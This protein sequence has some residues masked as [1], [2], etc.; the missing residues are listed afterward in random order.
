MHLTF[1]VILRNRP[2]N[3]VVYTT[4]GTLIAATFLG[5][6]NWCKN[7]YHTSYY[8]TDGGYQYYY[9]HE[10]AKFFQ[11]SSQTVFEV[12]V[13]KQLT[14]QLAFSAC[15]FESQADVYNSLHGKD[16]QERLSK[17]VHFFRRS[18]IHERADGLDW[19][20]NVTR[21]EEG[22]FLYRLIHEFTDLG[23]LNEQCF[24]VYNNGN[25]RDIESF[26]QKA[27]LVISTSPPRWVQ[28]SCTIPGCIL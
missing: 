11:T 8:E 26:C 19:M 18:N 25:R 13:L 7:V 15:T 22:W 21:L 17:F 4:E 24:S 2:S 1:F 14:A 5:R 16:D 9:P 20:L 27:M 6:C 10:N 12:E 3:P 28:H 23:I